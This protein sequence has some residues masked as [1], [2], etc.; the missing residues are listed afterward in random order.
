MALYLVKIPGGWINSCVCK[1]V[2]Q[3]LLN[4]ELGSLGFGFKCCDIVNKPTERHWE[5]FSVSQGDAGLKDEHD[6][7]YF[8]KKYFHLKRFKIILLSSSGGSQTKFSLFQS[9]PRVVLPD[10]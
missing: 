5:C 3:L 9:S 4:V 1:T 8:N 2:P 10:N 7:S 6:I